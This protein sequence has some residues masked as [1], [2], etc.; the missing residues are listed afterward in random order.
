MK[1]NMW[2]IKKICAQSQKPKQ[3]QNKNNVNIN[4]NVCLKALSVSFFYF[5]PVLGHNFDFQLL[6]MIQEM[7]ELRFLPLVSLSSSFYPFCS[8]ASL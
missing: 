8:F 1:E 4:K 3:K 2:K 5:C 7:A 6:A